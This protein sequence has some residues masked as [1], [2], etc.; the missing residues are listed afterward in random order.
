M[1]ECTTDTAFDRANADR[2]RGHSGHARNGLDVLVA[3]CEE[4]DP[5]ALETA[6]RA[7]FSCLEWANLKGPT[8]FT[9][10]AVQVQNLAVSRLLTIL[11]G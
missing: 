7:G 2:I 6:A 10:Q 9:W 5:H 8:D 4:P 1:K 3:A 11:T